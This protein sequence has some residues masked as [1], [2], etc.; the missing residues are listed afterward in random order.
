MQE[1]DKKLK[2]EKEQT[3]ESEI[4]WVYVEASKKEPQ[5]RELTKTD[6]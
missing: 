3:T 6:E 4:R 1:K 2:V 5:K